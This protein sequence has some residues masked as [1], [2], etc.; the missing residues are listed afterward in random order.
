[1]VHVCIVCEGIKGFFQKHLVGGDW[2]F[3]SVGG[4]WAFASLG[5]VRIR[6]WGKSLKGV[7]LS[8]ENFLQFH[9]IPF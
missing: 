9:Q 5:G 3:A 2:A 4:D 1:M 6:V 7:G 8:C